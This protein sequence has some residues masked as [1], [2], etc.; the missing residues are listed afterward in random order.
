MRS[1]KGEFIPNYDNRRMSL[2][3]FGRPDVITFAEDG[4]VW[5]RHS[6]NVRAYAYKI[7]SR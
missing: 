3:W 1:H 4:D 5:V 7:L 2:G 6:F